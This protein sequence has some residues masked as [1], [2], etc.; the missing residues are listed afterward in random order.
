MILLLFVYV[1]QSINF[2]TSSLSVRWAS[3]GKL[4]LFDETFTDKAI[5]ML[6]NNAVL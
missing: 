2:L 1:F 3:L 4:R 5:G 6:T